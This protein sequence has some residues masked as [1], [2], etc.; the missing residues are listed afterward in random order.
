MPGIL[1]SLP[2]ERFWGLS[3]GEHAPASSHVTH[4]GVEEVGGG[5]GWAER[6]PCTQ[7][8]DGSA[9]FCPLPAL[10]LSPELPWSWAAETA[11]LPLRPH[12][13]P[14]PGSRLFPQL[15]LSVCTIS[16]AFSVPEIIQILVL[17]IPLPPLGAVLNLLFF[18]HIKCC[19]FYWIFAGKGHQCICLICHLELEISSQP[20]MWRCS[21][22]Y[23]FPWA[24]L[25]DLYFPNSVYLWESINYD[26]KNHFPLKNSLFLKARASDHSK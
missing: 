23:C 13:L 10:T 7:S 4:V 8:F 5:Q 26:D 24:C 12:P 1:F 17:L 15:R 22:H 14:V 9:D 16:P 18:F 19:H 11:L 21:F 2:T 6:L 3:L 20:E 25:K